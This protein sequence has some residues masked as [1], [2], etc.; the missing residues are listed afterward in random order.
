MLEAILKHQSHDI[1]DVP[2]NDGS[3]L[4]AIELPIPT[5][6]S[7]AAISL[8]P[9]STLNA[10]LSQTLHSLLPSSEESEQICA[11]TCFVPCFFQQ[12]LSRNYMALSASDCFV[13]TGAQVA[14]LPAPNSH[15]IVIAQKMLMLACISQ[16]NSEHVKSASTK[17]ADWKTKMGQLAGSAIELVTTKDDLVRNAEG[18]E[19][20]M[21][22]ATYHANNGQIGQAF[23]TVRRAMAVAQLLGIHRSIHQTVHQVD[24]VAPRFN[25]SYMWYRIVYVDRLLCLILGLPQ[26]STDITCVDL[27]DI[28]DLT[29]EERLEREHCV[30]S[31]RILERNEQKPEPQGITQ[32]IDSSLLKA[33]SSLPS[34]WWLVPPVSRLRGARDKFLS[35]TRLVNQL[36]HF[37]LL[38]QTHL[39][40]LLKNETIYYYSKTIC[41]TASREILHRYLALKD[42]GFVAHAYNFVDFFAWIAAITLLLAHLHEQWCH[43]VGP[44]VLLHM[45]SSDRAVIEQAMNHLESPWTCTGPNILE[46]LFAVEEEAHTS[47]SVGSGNIVKD[48]PDHEPFFELKIP[49]YGKLRVN[50]VDICLQRSSDIEGVEKRIVRP[51][52]SDSPIYINQHL[53]DDMLFRDCISSELEEIHGSGEAYNGPGMAFFNSFEGFMEDQIS[54]SN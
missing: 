22:E 6:P 20:L 45:R 40:Y 26:G 10:T 1:S 47:R 51:L 23:S 18:L 14:M 19:C 30:I 50:S 13:L 39:P 15:P 29:P 35:T 25:P 34:S 16:Y 9:T 3:H 37:N 5:T 53:S 31:S 4:D 8:Y 54:N 48:N 21:L 17:F 43:H 52:T 41:T 32:S 38:N 27:A 24:P 12:M 46:Q 42:S 2:T 28:S 11:S 49:Y 36:F 33:A 44:T 7:N